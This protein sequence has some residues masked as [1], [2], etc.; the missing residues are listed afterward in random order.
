MKKFCNY[1]VYILIVEDIY[2]IK[3][4]DFLGKSLRNPYSGV[5]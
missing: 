3:K 5:G 4:T 1:Y 2:P